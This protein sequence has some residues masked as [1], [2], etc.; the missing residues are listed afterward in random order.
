[1]RRTLASEPC[2]EQGFFGCVRPFA[3]PAADVGDAEAERR[4]NMDEAVVVSALLEQRQRS[5]RERLQLVHATLT[6][7]QAVEARGDPCDRLPWNVA[8]RAGALRGG[9]G[10]GRSLLG[11]RLGAREVDLQGDVD[12]HRAQ[13]LERPF[14]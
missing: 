5:A 4:P 6:R 1:M 7:E 12:A 2:M 13:E 14:E 8:G 10:D 3:V 9:V 11:R